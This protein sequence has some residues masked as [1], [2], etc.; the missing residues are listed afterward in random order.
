MLRSGAEAIR[1]SD[2]SSRT[3]E[4]SRSGRN[5]VF[6]ASNAAASGVGRRA[7]ASSAS[8]TGLKTRPLQK[9]KQ[10]EGPS[11]TPGRTQLAV[12]IRHRRRWHRRQA[13]ALRHLTRYEERSAEGGRESPRSRRQCVHVDP[14]S[15]TVRDFVERWLRDWADDNVSNKTWTRYAQLLRKFLC[16]EFGTLP[17]QKLQPTHLQTLYTAMARDGLAPRTRLSLH[18][19][20]HT[21]LKHA[22]QWGVVARNV[23]SA[24][25][26][27]R[28]RAQEVEILSPAQVATVL[29]TLRDKPLYPIVAVLLRTGLRRSEVLAL[30]WQDVDLDGGTLQVEQ[31][32]EQTQRGGLVFRPPK[33]QHGRRM[34][35]LAPSTINVLRTHW[36]SQQ[37]HR[38]FFG[39]GKSPADALV[40][41]SW[42]GS[43]YLPSTL[44]LQWRRAMKRAGLK[45][46]LHSL[47]HTHAST[48]ITAG[49]DV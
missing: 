29:D 36:K 16:S 14:S 10:N 37:E 40:F 39:L 7:N 30:R 26:A 11:P 21:M 38:L 20:V 24:I 33:T 41:T 4:F 31:A 17:I 43:P 19:V 18:R 42:D 9:G 47:R 44:T 1:H 3:A 12:E 15:E 48:L 45:A 25:A 6:P 46:T 34:V 13:D 2:T 35:T 23:A 5:R 49:L 8:R 22:M 28:V 32:L 27:P